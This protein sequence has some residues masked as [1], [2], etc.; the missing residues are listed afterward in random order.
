MQ[1]LFTS[2]DDKAS[3][4][5]L[6]ANNQ[7]YITRSYRRDL[8]KMVNYYRASNYSVK[9]NHL[10]CRIITTCSTSIE[11]DIEHYMK[12]IN[13]RSAYVAKHYFLT[14]P[15]QYGRIHYGVFGNEKTP[16]VLVDV[17]N[18]FNI[19]SDYQKDDLWRRLCPVKCIGHEDSSMNLHLCDGG[20]HTS[21]TGM[22]YFT[23]DIP[24]LMFMYRQYLVSA[25]SNRE[26]VDTNTNIG[27][28]VKAYVLPNVAYSYT[29]L[30]IVNRL[31][32]LLS[33]RP[34]DIGTSK[35]P[36]AVIDYRDKL[37]KSLLMLVNRIKNKR[38]NYAGY[39]RCIPTLTAGDGQLAL[40][41]P[42]LPPVRQCNWMMLSSR[43]KACRLLIDLGGEEGRK[44]NLS[45]LTALKIEF[46]QLMRSR[47][48]ETVLRQL[49][50]SE[51]GH[52]FFDDVMMDIHAIGI[53]N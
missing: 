47:E 19:F 49:P 40:Q 32:N 36:I 20:D 4:P 29:D 48:L 50:S 17:S 37:D 33:G 12:T 39:L 45:L 15:L 1:T 27:H 8:N 10:L 22:M 18:Y 9:S 46:K 7:D 28:F 25:L 43:L 11:L 31:S 53:A 30:M 35:L 26:G 44:A 21:S 3:F 24:L 13:V 34:M 51:G 6:H 23:I 16:H 41:L 52:T 14:S 5:L 38:M 42:D 2:Y